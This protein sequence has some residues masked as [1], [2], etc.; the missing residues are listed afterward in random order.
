MGVDDINCAIRSGFLHCAYHAQYDGGSSVQFL[1]LILDRLERST[2]M[3]KT[4]WGVTPQAAMG[5]D[6]ALEADLEAREKFRRALD[7][8]EIE[9]D[10]LVVD[11]RPGTAL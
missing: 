11:P 6:K 8:G 4:I 2:P 5:R 1:L 3:M 7:A 9:M 10:S